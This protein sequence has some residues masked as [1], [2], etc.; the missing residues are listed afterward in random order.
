M[1]NVIGVF[2]LGGMSHMH[3][4]IPLTLL[5]SNG[6]FHR[7]IWQ[8]L[9]F[10]LESL[11]TFG[12]PKL[13]FKKKRSQPGREAKPEVNKKISRFLIDL[14]LIFFHFGS[15]RVGLLDSNQVY[16]LASVSR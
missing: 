5:V 8:I 2:F 15:S 13:F 4:D 10:N 12:L 6:L 3:L 7:Y 16:K 1:V 9:G 11:K 14:V